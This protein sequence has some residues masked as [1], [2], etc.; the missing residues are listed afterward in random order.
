MSGYL[1]RLLDRA[2]G[3]SLPEVRSLARAPYASA[4][5]P[6]DVSVGAGQ[7][8]LAQPPQSQA[9]P[10]D[11]PEWPPVRLDENLQAAE[12]QTRS[13]WSDP[14]RAAS[15]PSS[16]S[17]T[18]GTPSRDP[19]AGDEV[20]TLGFGSEPR[21]SGRPA[22]APRVPAGPQLRVPNRLF[23]ADDQANLGTG[24]VSP[25]R[26]MPGPPSA[27]LPQPSII[28]RGQVRAASMASLRDDLPDRLDAPARFAAPSTLLAPQPASSSR[29]PWAVAA[30]QPGPSIH[31]V[32]AEQEPTEVHV[33]IG[34][35]EVTA[36]HEAPPARKR[37]EP[38][39]RTAPSLEDYLAQRQRGVSR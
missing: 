36:V 35:I 6:L 22:A 39:P 25:T 7:I 32:A 27:D 23:D 3:R 28:Q 38:P 10:V 1:Q 17:E 26:E 33:H 34:R 21:T 9:S 16:W 15:R 31:A 12:R 5:N 14:D 19:A 20:G 11:R 2:A 4:S 24:R 13:Q 8:A 37:P 30:K 29:A 18:A